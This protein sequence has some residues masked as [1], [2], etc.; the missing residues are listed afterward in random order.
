MANLI[1]ILVGNL[2][3]TFK[4]IE[5][6]LFIGLTASLVLV[7]LATTDRG[8]TGAQRLM[9]ADINAPAALVA[10]V[11]LITYFVAGAFAAFYFLARR[12]IVRRLLELDPLVVDAILT[13]PSVVSRI[14]AP[15]LVALLSIAGTGLA[16]L[17]LFYAP[18][19]E[20]Q[21]ALQAYALMG[22]PY[23]VLFAMAFFTAIEERPRR[24]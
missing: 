7:V 1:E 2:K 14:G 21:K 10:S 20:T 4:A 9:F 15:Q 18:I 13:Y 12:R 6:F 16:A 8:L 24:A 3:E 23:V 22:A 11:A 5:K 17:L 19:H